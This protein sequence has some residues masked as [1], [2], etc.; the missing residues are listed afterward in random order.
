MQENLTPG[1]VPIRTAAK[2]L[3]MDQ[4]TVRVLLQRGEVSWGECLR[5]PGSR[6]NSYIIYA[7]PFFELTGYRAEEEWEND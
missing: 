7:K 6:K 4:Q 3:K 2:V 5:L 1:R